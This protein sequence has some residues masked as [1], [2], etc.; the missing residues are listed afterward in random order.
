MGVRVKL[1]VAL[2]LY[3]IFNIGYLF[4]F[5]VI[6]IQPTIANNNII[7]VIINHIE[8]FPYNILPILVI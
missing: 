3:I 5:K 1:L 2:A 6:T 4:S 7:E 8:K